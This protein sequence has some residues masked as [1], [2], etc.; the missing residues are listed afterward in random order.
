VARSDVVQRIVKL[1]GPSAELVS[2]DRGWPSLLNVQVSSGLVRVALHAGH[3]ADRS[4][5][6]RDQLERRM[7]NPGQDHPVI[8]M[9]GAVSAILGLW[10]E[11]SRPLLVAFD[12]S[13][14]IGKTTRQSFFAALPHLRAAA[15]EG[16]A[17]YRTGS[18]ED[19]FAFWPEMLPAYVEMLSRGARLEADAVSSIIAAAGLGADG[20][21][22]TA[23]E[24]VRRATIALVRRAAFSREVLEAYGALC[25]MCGL[26]FGLVEGAH[27]FPASAQGSSDD[28]RN[29]LALCANHHAAF[30]R[31]LV[32][33]HPSNHRLQL[34]P[35]L[36]RGASESA[37][38][39]AFVGSTLK[40]LR[41]PSAVRHHPHP[42]MFDRRYVHFEG[43]YKWCA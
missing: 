30:D 5:R 17:S 9:H 26:D 36:L 12:A 1:V 38:C 35:N 23:A 16:W 27:I 40:A 25:A 7:Q 18:S 10:D 33:V 14:R 11:E 3:F 32:H 13:A 43:A 15:K 42:R 22:L 6:D 24:R 4:Y 28:V 34:H 19:V 8:N 2:V 41:L 29:G 20:E 37:G 39:E 21:E 31:H